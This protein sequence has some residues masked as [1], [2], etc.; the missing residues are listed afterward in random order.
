MSLGSSVTHAI[1]AVQWIELTGSTADDGYLFVTAVSTNDLTIGGD[2]LTGGEVLDETD[3]ATIRGSRL[4]NGTTENSFT[5]ERYH[6]DKDKY[7]TFLGMVVSTLNINVAASSI[8][9]GGLEF[10]GKSA[11]VAA[12][13]TGSGYS[14][15]AT[16]HT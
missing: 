10:I 16:R 5:I 1:T 4:Q 13:T 11:A 6:A 7:F 9:T 8:L 3:A 14:A 12:T 2:G 15:A